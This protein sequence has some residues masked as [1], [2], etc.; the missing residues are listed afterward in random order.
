MMNISKDFAPPFSMVEPFF[1][2]GSIFY[3][4]AM[5]GALFLDPLAAYTNFSTV[6]WIHWFMLG[7]VMMVIFGAMAQLVP[8]VLEVGHFSVDLYYVI[9][10]TLLLGTIGMSVGFL[11]DSRVLPLGGMLVLVSMVIFLYE[12][13]MTLK[14]AE[15]ITITV[16]SIFASNIF[17]ATAIIIGFVMSLS[18]G[19]GYD[20][21]VSKWLGAHAVLALIG[22]VTLT[23]MGLSMVLL[24]MFGLSHGFDQKP[25]ERSFWLMSGGVVLYLLGTIIDSNSMHYVALVAIFVA[26]ALYL[27]QIWII[28]KTRARKVHDVYAKSLYVGY[29]SLAISLVLGVVLLF[30]HNQQI[31][32]GASWFFLMGFVSFLI[33]GHL[34]KIV[35]FLVWFER[36]SPLVGKAPVPMLADMLPKKQVELQ[37]VLTSVGLIISGV[38]IVFGVR[39]IYI[40]G[41]LP[42]IAGGALVFYN[43]RFMLSFGEIEIEQPKTQEDKDV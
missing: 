37:F 3:L 34:Y 24:P 23:I 18:I 30:W 10:P 39:W 16:K 17:L 13:F 40:L 33:I 43:M 20:V 12:T 1:K 42:L 41:V 14:K 7:F 5:I 11:Y 22:Y 27:Y 38:G 35:P 8:V 6:A 32:M 28:Y 36:Y 9:W 31:M 15:R 25:I 21:D 19:L 2:I 29:G 26:T 4:L